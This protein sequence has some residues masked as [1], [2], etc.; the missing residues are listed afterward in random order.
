LFKNGF[1]IETL[2]NEAISTLARS[3]NLLHYTP[4]L[5]EIISSVFGISDFN[6]TTK[7]QLHQLINETLLS[8]HKGE[9]TLKSLLV[10]EFVNKN[11]VSAFEIK[12]NSSRADFLVINGDTKSF[13]IKSELD[14][15][16]KLSKQVSDYAEVFEFNHIVIDLKHYEKA[17]KIIPNEYGIWSFE[18][19]KKIVLRKSTKNEQLNP[20]LQLKL[21]TKKELLTN[22]TILDINEIVNLFN[23]SEINKTFKLMLKKRYKKRWEFLIK[24]KENI[25]PIDYQ[26]FFNSNINPNDIYNC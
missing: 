12:V 26:F 6:G 24:N 8:K 3:Y 20:L 21:F 2:N 15:L 25:L 19:G 10:E 17:I 13:E 9:N 22:F 14:N 7:Y 1:N 23:A 11:A 18:N 5:Q 4:K 16:S